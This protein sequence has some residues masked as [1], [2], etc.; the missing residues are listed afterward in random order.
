M[1]TGEGR[2]T[3]RVW[4]LVGRGVKGVWCVWGYEELGV[5]SAETL[6]L[7]LHQVQVTSIRCF[8]GTKEL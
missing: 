4:G 7:S 6:I 3:R 5:M 2:G 8:E 1:G